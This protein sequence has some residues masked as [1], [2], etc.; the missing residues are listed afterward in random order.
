MNK[1]LIKEIFKNIQIKL[2][3]LQGSDATF[4]FIGDEGN[5]FV[6]GGDFNNIVAQILFAMVR[7]PVI[8]KIIYK[9]VERY[10]ETE[11]LYGEDIKNVKMQHLIEQNSGNDG[12]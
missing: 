6:I 1:D 5:H 4:L 11:K 10:E 8:R 7:Y 12:N 2:D 9:C 3:S